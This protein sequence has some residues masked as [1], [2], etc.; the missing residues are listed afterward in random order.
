MTNRE[1]AER[2]C[3]LGCQLDDIAN[4]DSLLL[5]IAKELH[6]LSN[7]NYTPKTSTWADI[8]K[9]VPSKKYKDSR[10]ELPF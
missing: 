6:T 5:A 10:G 4:G 1:L 8:K 9:Q 3:S 2:L 7:E